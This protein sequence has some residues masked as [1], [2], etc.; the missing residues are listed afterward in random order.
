MGQSAYFDALEPWG[1]SG[2]TMFFFFVFFWGGVRGNNWYNVMLVVGRRRNS[3]PLLN[4]D[5]FVHF[6][7]K[8]TY[9]LFKIF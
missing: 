7:Q 8:M 6:F 5:V 1:T 9:C 2:F 3:F 4:I